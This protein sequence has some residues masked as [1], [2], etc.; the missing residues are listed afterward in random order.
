[1]PDTET[2][3]TERP[4]F[5]EAFANDI[6]P[7]SAPERTSSE[8]SDADP[9]S[10]AAPLSQPTPSQTDES[11]RAQRGPIPYDRHEAVL[12][13]ARNDHARAL[14]QERAKAEQYSWLRPYIDAGLNPE[15]LTYLVQMG[16][17]FAGDKRGFLD[18]LA[19]DPAVQEWAAARAAQ[20]A[21]ATQE[22]A[23][24]QPDAVD[25]RTGEAYY[26]PAQQRVWG[27]WNRRQL[28]GET[29]ALVKPLLTEREERLAREKTEAEFAEAHEQAS[30]L[31]G[32]YKSLP[33]FMENLPAIRAKYDE[34]P[35]GQKDLGYAYSLVMQ[36]VVLPTLS[37]KEQDHV[38]AD[39][40][41]Q[42]HAASLNPK[43]AAPSESARPKTFFD[44]P[45]SAWKP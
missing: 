2:Q 31:F 11:T 38:V 37:Q 42:A 39:M 25:Q 45:E 26:S 23:E 16:A 21:K 9:N 5:E 22:D 7:D 4:S 32:R 12:T 13:K 18:A 17:K 35:R 3:P 20:Q 19:D 30:S 24:P 44:L 34:L 40:K 29:E 33:H 43:G 15:R 27:E 41:R 28:R 6:S 14:E 10:A 1:M 8:A 36:D